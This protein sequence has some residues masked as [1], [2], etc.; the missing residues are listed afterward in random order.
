MAT[1]DQTLARASE[2]LE[3]IVGK[4]LISL[5]IMS[6]ARVH[7]SLSFSPAARKGETERTREREGGMEG[8]NWV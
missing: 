6:D 3:E 1:R 7:L 2:T 5:R 8:E 4:S